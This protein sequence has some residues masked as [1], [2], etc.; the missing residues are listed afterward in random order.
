MSDRHDLA[1]LIRARDRDALAGFFD[2]RGGYVVAYCGGL[3]APGL[4]DEAALAAFVEFLARVDAAAPGSDLDLLLVKA[5]RGCAA[6]RLDLHDAPAIC[7]AAP[8]LLA[9]SANG[10]LR[11]SDDALARHLEQCERCQ[12]TAQRLLDGERALKDRPA[13]PATDELRE[14]WLRVALGAP[15]S[16]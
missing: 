15:A 10:E 6:A 2:G 4:A 7:R 16:A 1:E 9:A 14:E 3:C 8:E 11:H 13:A 12:A 5:T